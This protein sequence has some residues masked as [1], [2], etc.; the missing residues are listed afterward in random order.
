MRNNLRVGRHGGS[1]VSCQSLARLHSIVEG[2]LAT[3]SVCRALP[4]RIC[5][6]SRR[7]QQG[8]FN[9]NWKRWKPTITQPSRNKNRRNALKYLQILQ[10]NRCW[11]AFQ[12]RKHHSKFLDRR[13]YPRRIN[14]TSKFSHLKFSSFENW[15]PGNNLESF[16]R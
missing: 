3:L 2:M 5:S 6:S 14:F 9:Q 13:T 8:N 12:L 16:G 11:K 10:I 15:W 7:W 4:K 1:F